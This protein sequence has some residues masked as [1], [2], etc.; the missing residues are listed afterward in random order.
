MKVLYSWGTRN[1]GDWQQCD[2]SEYRVLP[3]AGIPDRGARGDTDNTPGRLSDLMIQGVTFNGL[4]HVAVAPFLDTGEDG[5][6]VWAW[7][8]DPA[9]YPIGQRVARIWEF[10][11][12]APDPTFGSGDRERLLNSIRNE[13][14]ITEQ[15]RT[16]VLAWHNDPAHFP[17]NTRQTQVVYAEGDRYDR[18]LNQGVPV[19][20]WAEFEGTI[21]QTI[22]PA[23]TR[24]G[25]WVPDEHWERQVEAR[26]PTGWMHWNEHLPESECEWE[27]DEI[28]HNKRARELRVP[29]RVLKEQRAQG[30]YS[31]ATHTITYY[32]RDTNL[33]AG[34]IA[35]NAA[36]RENALELTTA[37]SATEAVTTTT[38]GLGRAEW[39]FSSPSNEPN[40]A[41]WPSGVYHVQVNCTAL[42]AG[43]STIFP[44]TAA[45]PTGILRLASDLS[46]MLEGILSP[47][48][49]GHVATGLVLYTSDAIDF[50]A[51]AAIDRFGFAIS[52]AG[53]SHG[54]AITLQFNTTDSYADGPWSSVSVYPRSSIN[55]Q[56]VKRA[57]TW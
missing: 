32:Q 5:V 15:R 37:G 45:S 29:R 43:T 33:A 16:E 41:D 18:L 26:T 9:D 11:P 51:G 1:P 14:G 10:L 40:S 34:W 38:N 50:A 4:D 25:I 42:S 54:D 30:R 8:D 17:L 46:S 36:N 13:P 31:L 2:A 49:T 57:A 47:T 7:N 48:Q 19:R 3:N 28:R 44:I 35:V 53:D 6:R 21:L 55:L 23:I 22:D 20:H 27:R 12:L 39:A 24:H 52:A 56:A